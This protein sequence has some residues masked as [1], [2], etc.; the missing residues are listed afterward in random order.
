ML[1]MV[2]GGAM[3]YQ[4]TW[5][6]GEGVKTPISKMWIK[7]LFFKTLSL[8]SG[9]P[10]EKCLETNIQVFQFLSVAVAVGISDNN[11]VKCDM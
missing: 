7:I 10:L 1:I 6:K 4:P 9:P 3:R 5:M 11:Q 8:P 2:G